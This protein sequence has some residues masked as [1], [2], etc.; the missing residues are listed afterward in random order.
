MK[1]NNTCTT[2]TLIVVACLTS[3]GIQAA[4]RSTPV[5][6]VND[7]TR[8]VPVAGAVEVTRGTVSIDNSP[9]NPVP[10]T[11]PEPLQV[12]VGTRYRFVGSSAVATW[13]NIGVNGMNGVCRTSFGAESRMCTSK[14]FFQTPDTTLLPVGSHWIMPTWVTV[15]K[16]TTVSGDPTVVRTSYA[17][18]VNTLPERAGSEMISCNMFTSNNPSER[19]FIVGMVPTLPY[20]VLAPRQCSSVLPIACCAP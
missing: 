2:K 20:Q 14:E 8:P 7:A 1:T 9:T 17:G 15:H 18:R 16:S 5:T 11:I 19:G 3:L 12:T 10:V 4:P 13:P 6:V